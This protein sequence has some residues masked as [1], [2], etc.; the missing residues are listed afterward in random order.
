MMY[1]AYKLNKQVI[2]SVDVLL[3]Q[4]WTSLLFH[5]RF[6]LLMFSIWWDIILFLPFNSL[7]DFLN[8]SNVF[9]IANWKSS[10]SK[11]DIQAFS[12][13]ISIDCFF[14]WVWAILSCFSVCLIISLLE[15]RHFYHKTFFIEIYTRIFTLF[16]CIISMDFSTKTFSG[17][18]VGSVPDHCNKVNIA[19]KWVTAFFHFFCAHK[20]YV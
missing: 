10:Y 3:S 19:R 5:I 11:S 7:H 1:S 8:S 17:D 15:S 4:F 20:S 16:K 2:Y 6:S 9:M 13:I 18:T 12:G 14:S